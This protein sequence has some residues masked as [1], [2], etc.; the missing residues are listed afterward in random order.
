MSMVASQSTTGQYPP[1]DDRILDGGGWQRTP[2]SAGL[3]KI[4]RCTSRDCRSQNTT[5][6]R[7]AR[8]SHQVGPSGYSPGSAALSLDYT[9]RVMRPLCF[10]KTTLRRPP[11][12]ESDFH[13][14][15][16]SAMCVNSRGS[17]RL[18]FLRRDSHARTSAS[19]AA[20]QES[21]AIAQA[22]SRMS[23]DCSMR[24]LSLRAGCSSKTS[25][26]CCDCI[27]AKACF[28]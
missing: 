5:D 26:S 10:A 28:S 8:N 21:V 24:R 3:G 25:R 7:R 18:T 13:A 19:P 27:T 2:S 12:S 11:S 1:F 15:S 20:P 23:S 17:R 9:E 6:Q 4:A 22:S 14:S 16:S